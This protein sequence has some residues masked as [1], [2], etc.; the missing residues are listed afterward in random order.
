LVAS[1][2]W[3]TYFTVWHAAI[4]NATIFI[5]TQKI[6]LNAGKAWGIWHTYCAISK[7]QNFN[8]KCIVTVYL[9]TNDARR[10]SIGRIA[11][12]TVSNTT[13]NGA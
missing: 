8:A 7:T 13:V 9:V 12:I 4:H 11:D 10:A 6:S 1:C 3:G 5:S 2:T